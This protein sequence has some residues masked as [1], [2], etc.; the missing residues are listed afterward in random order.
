MGLGENVRGFRT[1]AGMTQDQLARDSGLSRAT[2]SR[3]EKG[4]VTRLKSD[5]L[6]RVA[7]ALGVTVD[8]LV[9]TRITLSEQIGLSDEV[10]VEPLNDALGILRSYRNLSEK[11]REQLRKFLRFLEQEERIDRRRGG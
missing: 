6:A 5:A 7:D 11:A 10:H 4:H 9:T 3:L 8:D 2:I 1:R